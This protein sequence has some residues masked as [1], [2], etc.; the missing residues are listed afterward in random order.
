[1]IKYYVHLSEYTLCKSN[2]S[3]CHSIRTRYWKQINWQIWHKSHKII[4]NYFHELFEYGILSPKMHVDNKFFVYK[5][6]NLY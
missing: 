2:T 3:S 6:V 1:M 5:I 4:E